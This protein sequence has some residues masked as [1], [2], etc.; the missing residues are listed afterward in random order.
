MKRDDLIK[1]ILRLR[2]NT[3]RNFNKIK[4]YKESNP[5]AYSYAQ[6][7]YEAEVR[8]IKSTVKGLESLKTR[9]LESTLRELKY[10]KGLKTSTLKSVK[11]INSANSFGS[12][13]NKAEA[14]AQRMGI[15]VDDLKSAM[16][17]AYKRAY[18]ESYSIERYKYQTMDYI[19]DYLEENPKTPAVDGAE[20]FMENL[21][22]L[23]VAL[24][25]VQKVDNSISTYE[26]DGSD[27]DLI[28][29]RDFVRKK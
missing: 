10:I 7:E 23:Q 11:K 2:S 25:A 13:L 3:L 24:D 4:R 6:E 20:Q 29:I 26:L 8:K 14:T 15:S 17:K 5:E 28:D 9:E 1:D 16:F 12:V 19:L 18:H 22:L 27:S 21:D